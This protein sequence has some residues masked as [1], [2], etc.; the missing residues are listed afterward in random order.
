MK[1]Q[2]FQ[3]LDELKAADKRVGMIAALIGIQE[4]FGINDQE[5]IRL[6]VEWQKK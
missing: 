3:Y 6:F 2:V 4:K 1:E 5:A